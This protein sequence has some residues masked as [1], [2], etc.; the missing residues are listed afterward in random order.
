MKF[1]LHTYDVWGNERDGFEVNDR[2]MRRDV[3]EVPDDATDADFILALKRAGWL[4][5]NVRVSSIGIEGESDYTL[6]FT[7]TPTG[8]PLFE[9]ER[10]Q[11]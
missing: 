3:I 9:L 6:Y 10:R 5:R 11:D 2:Y 8:Y 7:H 4:K 1:D